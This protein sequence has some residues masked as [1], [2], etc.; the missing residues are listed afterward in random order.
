MGRG[1]AGARGRADGGRRPGERWET[2]L[3]WIYGPGGSTMLVFS[4]VYYFDVIL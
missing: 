4:V 1:I 3:T 2:R